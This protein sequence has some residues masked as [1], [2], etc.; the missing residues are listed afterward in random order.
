MTICIKQCELYGLF[1]I[2][3]NIYDK[4]WI[5]LNPVLK[6]QLLQNKV[7]KILNVSV[8]CVLAHVVR[9]FVSGVRDGGHAGARHGLVRVVWAGV[10]AG[11]HHG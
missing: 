11:G 1:E 8:S 10:Y 4:I 7:G 6:C 5:Y 2:V 9:A 3:Y